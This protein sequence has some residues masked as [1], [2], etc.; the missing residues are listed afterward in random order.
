MGPVLV[1]MRTHSCRQCP[2][3]QPRIRTNWKMA[4]SQPDVKRMQTYW[5]QQPIVMSAHGH[6]SFTKRDRATKQQPRIHSA[7]RMLSRT[8][9]VFFGYS[10]YSNC[11]HRILGNRKLGYNLKISYFS[12]TQLQLKCS[13]QT[14]MQHRT[15]TTD[16]D[17]LSR[18][19]KETSQYK[20][21]EHHQTTT[22]NNSLWYN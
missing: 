10:P 20:H 14:F 4:F 15:D 13:Y 22:T 1:D 9:H 2:V 12:C 7:Q 18:P 6:A 3:V 21:C 8:A 16:A 17:R 11:F 5:S 19:Y